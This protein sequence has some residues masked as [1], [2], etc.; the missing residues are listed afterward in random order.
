MKGVVYLALARKGVIIACVFLLLLITGCG[1]QRTETKEAN[2]KAEEIQTNKE[3]AER[4]IEMMLKAYPYVKKY[5]IGSEFRSLTVYIDNSWFYWSKE[6]KEEN[7]RSFAKIVRNAV[8]SQKVEMKSENINVY[9]KNEDG[10]LL[11]FQLEDGK[12]TL[13]FPDI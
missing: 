6:V 13:D 8:E 9:I 12:V 10:G 4:E 7:L 2:K 3:F 1:S 11:L 5:E